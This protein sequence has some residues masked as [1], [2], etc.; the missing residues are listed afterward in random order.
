MVS[1]ID[2]ANVASQNVARRLGATDSGQPPAHDADC[3]VWTY[4]DIA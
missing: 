1:Y 3:T 4:G 2:R